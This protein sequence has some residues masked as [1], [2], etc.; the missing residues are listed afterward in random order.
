ME[1]HTHLGYGMLNAGVS[2]GTSAWELQAQFAIN[3]SNV[4]DVVA[5]K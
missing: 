1:T 4:L 2:I 3:V 5:A